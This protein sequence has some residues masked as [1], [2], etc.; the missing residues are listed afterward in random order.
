MD[1][2]SNHGALKQHFLMRNWQYDWFIEHKY[3]KSACLIGEYKQIIHKWTVFNSKAFN[4]QR[5]RSQGL[6]GWFNQ[7]I[8]VGKTERSRETNGFLHQK[9]PWGKRAWLVVWNLAF[10]T[11]HILGIVPPTDELIFFRGVGLKTTNQISHW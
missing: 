8:G 1:A 7:R 9:T 10:M 2:I 4:Y 3:G 5:V 6:I 11:F